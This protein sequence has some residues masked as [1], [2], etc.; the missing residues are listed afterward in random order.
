MLLAATT[1]AMAR[2][3]SAQVLH[4][5]R[6]HPRVPRQALGHHHLQAR[7]MAMVADHRAR[8]SMQRLRKILDLSSGVFCEQWRREGLDQIVF[9]MS[10]LRF[11]IGDVS[12]RCHW[13]EY[14]DLKLSKHLII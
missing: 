8:R 4:H 13:F 3:K 5:T 6:S 12:C 9:E 11:G 10:R 2:R 14:F 7:D 1:R